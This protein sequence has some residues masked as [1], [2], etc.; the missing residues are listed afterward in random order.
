[1]EQLRIA[2]WNDEVTL[3]TPV[4]ALPPTPQAA[5]SQVPTP[6]TFSQPPTPQNY[7]RVYS[8]PDEDPSYQNTLT[9]SNPN[10]QKRMRLS[11]KPYV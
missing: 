2:F 4:V 8:E 3:P 10:A 6:Q 7:K 5:P 11:G 1:M 9:E